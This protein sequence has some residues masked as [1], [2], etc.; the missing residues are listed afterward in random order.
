MTEPQARSDMAGL[1]VVV[2]TKDRPQM[3]GACL[4][5]LRAALRDG[6]ELI[7][8]DSA[9]RDAAAVAAV[10]AA[11]G[12]RVVRCAE[13][14]ASRARNAGAKAS[15]NDIVA[16]VDDDVRV[17]PG[18]AARIAA[19]FADPNVAFVTGR[20]DAPPGQ[21]ERQRLVA[22]K[23]DPDPAVLDRDTP[24]PLGAS[25]NLAIQRTVLDQV[26]GFDELLGGGAP[27]EAAE[28]LDLFDRLLAAGFTGRY[29]PAALAWHEQW[30][31][32]WEVVRLDWRYGIGS[33]ARLAKLVRADRRRLRRTVREVFWVDGLCIIGRSLRSFERLAILTTMARL[34]ANFV[35]FARGITRRTVD[36]HYVARRP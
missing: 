2:P 25:A 32:G 19:T 29:E 34:L 17:A 23:D 35:G 27:L 30:R 8:V 16:F 11:A 20:V 4:D 24:S 7:V 10:A 15:A 36:G 9:S 28:D 22:V 18:W 3:L 12:G 14:G 6:D 26:G 21:T 5:A 1:S 31:E 33:G 13:P